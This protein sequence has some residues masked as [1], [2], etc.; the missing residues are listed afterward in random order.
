V[1]AMPKKV[2]RGRSAIPTDFF[3]ARQGWRS[4]AVRLVLA[5]ISSRENLTPARALKIAG[6]S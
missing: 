5:V 4:P 3:D 2:G 6:V 1:R